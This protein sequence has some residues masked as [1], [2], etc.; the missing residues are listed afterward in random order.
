M[1]R[2]L[3]LAAVACFAVAAGGAGGWIAGRELLTAEEAGAR[4]GFCLP[5]L[6]HVETRIDDW[7]WPGADVSMSSNGLADEQRTPAC[8]QTVAWSLSTPEDFDAVTARYGA[9]LDATVAQRS[10]RGGVASIAAALPTAGMG[11]AAST[12]FTN[13]VLVFT[14]VE[15]SGGALGTGRRA[16]LGLRALDARADVFVARDA[17]DTR[18]HVTIVLDALDAE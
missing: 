17:A 8:R 18:T 4:F 6:A 14:H 11:S 2:T 12:R 7:T 5:G 15:P 3:T 9:F 16:A 1:A 10:T 13:G